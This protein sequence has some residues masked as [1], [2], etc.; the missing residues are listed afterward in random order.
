MTDIDRLKEERRKLYGKV[1]NQKKSYKLVKDDFEDKCHEIDEILESRYEFQDE[2]KVKMGI[3]KNLQ[4]E[5]ER[6]RE[7]Q[8]N[9]QTN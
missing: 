8:K 2:M 3:L 4:I 9:K 6:V 1:K 5:H 7:H